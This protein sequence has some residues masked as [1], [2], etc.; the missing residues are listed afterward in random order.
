[1]RT[2]TV[3]D[4]HPYTGQFPQLIFQISCIP[5]FQITRVPRLTSLSAEQLAE[6]FTLIFLAE[7]RYTEQDV[8]AT[9][10]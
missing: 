5:I 4:K 7:W 9:L 8:R 3:L 2:S 10:R 6:A 1:M